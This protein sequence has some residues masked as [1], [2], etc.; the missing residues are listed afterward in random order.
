MLRKD[1]AKGVLILVWKMPINVFKRLKITTK[2]AENFKKYLEGCFSQVQ[3]VNL[4]NK[5]FCTSPAYFSI[6]TH[7]QFRKFQKQV[8]K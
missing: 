6:D 8:T 2:E 4:K 1:I 7:N 5:S 3:Q